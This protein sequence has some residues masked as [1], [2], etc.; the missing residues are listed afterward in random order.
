MT[1]SIL[2]RDA[3]TGELGGAAATGNLC[4]GG[5]VL[6]GDCRAGVSASQGLSPS[7]L[8][9]ED[10]LEAM[11]RGASAEDAV[12]SVVA[13]DAGRES[14]QLLAIDRS[15]RTGVF[16]GARNTPVIE[17]V[18]GDAWAVGG[19]WL[20]SRDVIDAIAEGFASAEG[21]L[22]E[23]LMA[24]LAAG[25]AAGSDARGTMSAALL[26]VSDRHAPLDLR[27]DFDRDPIGRLKD[28]HARTL[29]P[30]YAKWAR[31]VPSRRSP[32]FAP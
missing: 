28:L 22:A 1:F 3:A 10:V 25:Q 2:A 4:V 7:T 32:G 11:R 14:R 15:G 26:V 18:T 23:R 12:S 8:W 17:A 19:N 16:N 13:A 9:G 5:W 24:G 27:I 30:D 6:R 31:L 29:E 20:M 21:S